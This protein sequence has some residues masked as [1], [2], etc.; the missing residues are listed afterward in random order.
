MSWPVYLAVLNRIQ[1]DSQVIQGETPKFEGETLLVKQP[2]KSFL[3]L[4]NFND[5]KSKL[6]ELV[7]NPQIPE[8]LKKNT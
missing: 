2:I 8:P 7:F 5:F 4:F 3:S 1:P 6:P